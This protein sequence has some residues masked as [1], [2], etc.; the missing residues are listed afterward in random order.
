LGHRVL[1]SADHES[2]IRL[3]R[4]EHPDLVLTGVIIGK[5]DGYELVRRIRA[6]VTIATTPILFVAASGEERVARA[7]ARAADV[8]CA[9]RRPG[10][11]S[12]TLM[13]E[14]ALA[15]KH[16]DGDTLTP[17]DDESRDTGVTD[18]LATPPKHRAAGGL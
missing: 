10:E 3:L 7:L 4:S 6:D 2:G 11:E 17:G 16:S 12:V 8:E 18:S 14:R 1:D 13:I 5:I 9:I 15:G